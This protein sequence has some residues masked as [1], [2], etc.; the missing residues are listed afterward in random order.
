MTDGAA[1]SDKQDQIIALVGVAGWVAGECYTLRPQDEV[2]I[3]RSR[4]C[5]ISLRR[6]R[7]YL[8]KSRYDRDNDHDFNTVSRRHLQVSI[9]DERY[10]RLEDLSTNG[11][12]VD[13]VLMSDSLDIDTHTQSVKIRLGTREVLQVR[14][15]T[16]DELQ[17]RERQSALPEQDP[18]SDSDESASDLAL[19][20]PSASEAEGLGER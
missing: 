5:D 20:S 16:E 2:I 3:G 12:Y 9:I 17:E 15:F 6:C 11:T 13:D 8:S 10:I 4:S 1:D 7:T 14:T 19:E 18:Q